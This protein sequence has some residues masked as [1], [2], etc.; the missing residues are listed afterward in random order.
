MAFHFLMSMVIEKDELV[1]LQYF[2]NI[3]L[4]G[5]EPMLQISSLDN[6]KVIPQLLENLEHCT[7]AS[8]H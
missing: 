6:I 5:C 7:K 4:N 1:L 3:R 2:F 8:F